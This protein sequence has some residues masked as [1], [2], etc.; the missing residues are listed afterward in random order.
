M[1]INFRARGQFLQHDICTLQST[2]S[3]P[4]VGSH[5][6]HFRPRSVCRDQLLY[7][8]SSVQHSALCT[9]WSQRRGSVCT[10]SFRL[11]LRLTNVDGEVKC[12][13]VDLAAAR[14]R[15]TPC[16]DGFKR[17]CVYMVVV[18]QTSAGWRSRTNDNQTGVKHSSCQ[19]SQ[20][21]T[22]SL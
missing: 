17:R 20:S 11:I 13:E 22:E 1:L 16:D 10:P 8:S 4:H 3:N 9:F 21:G 7:E 6:S 14:F 12:G 5:H 15:D 18:V 19:L 2:D